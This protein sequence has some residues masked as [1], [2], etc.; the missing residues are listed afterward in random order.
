MSELADR[1][2]V[3]CRGGVEPLKGAAL[4][5][6]HE[7][8]GGDWKLID[9]HHL[10]KEFKFPDF[11]TALDFVNRVGE[12]A[13]TVDHHPDLHVAWGKVKVVIWTHK[14]DGLSETDFVFAAKAD[15]LA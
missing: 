10:V 11:G 6:L 9:E 7:Q 14:I 4:Q 1:E 8:L 13:E 2:C 3:P 12:L 15:R 5:A